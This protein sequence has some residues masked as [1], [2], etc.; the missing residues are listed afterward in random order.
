MIEQKGDV[1]LQEKKV[2]TAV[3]VGLTAVIAGYFMVWLPGPAAGLQFIGLE[4]GEWV[5]FMGVDQSRNLFYLPPVTLGLVLMLLTATWSNRRWQTWFTRGI[6]VA[7][8]GLA[9]P[10]W[11]DLNGFSQSEYLP[12]IWYIAF[13]I[14]VGIGV[15]FMSRRQKRPYFRTLPWVL[16]AIVAVFGLFLPT[17]IYTVVTPVAENWLQKPLGMGIGVWLNG[18]GH[19]LITAVCLF[20]LLKS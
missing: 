8:S 18:M 20:K 19:L 5:K 4:M 9:F 10:A 2:E 13:V 14:V 15:V 12:R 3:F 7:I 6:A 16:M 1:E 17:W 11:E